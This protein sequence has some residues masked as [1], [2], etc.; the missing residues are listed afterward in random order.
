MARIKLEMPANFTFKTT[1]PVRITDLN[2]GGHVGNDVILSIVHEARVQFYNHLGYNELHFAGVSTI[3]SDCAVVYKNE[4]FYGD[5]L[6]I[7]V[8]AADLNKYGF[9]LFFK[10]SNQ[11][12]GKTVAEAK[13]GIVCFDYTA[14]K[15][16]MLPEEARAK[17]SA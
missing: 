12:N 17:L 1:V 14:R 6:T 15:V 16:A 8:A 10:L 4:S 11:A 5:V 7:E 3:M 13:T 2:Y 9:D